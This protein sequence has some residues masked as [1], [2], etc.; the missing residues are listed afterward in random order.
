MSKHGIVSVLGCLL[1][2]GLGTEADTRAFADIKHDALVTTL[3]NYLNA[4]RHYLGFC[5]IEVGQALNDKGVDVILS[6]EGCRVGFQVKSHFDVTEDDFAAK[7]KRQF[8]EALSYK[9]DHYYILICSAMMKKGRQDYKQRVAHLLNEIRLFQ[10]VN[11]DAFG[12]L[13]TIKYFRAP[14]TVTRDELLTRKA[15]ADDCLYDF[16]KGYEHLPEVDSGEIRAAHKRLAEEYGDDWWDDKNGEAA[17]HE[18]Q[19]L[20]RDAEAKQFTTKFLPSLPPEV[21]QKRADLIASIQTLL[22]ECRKCKSWQDRSEYKLPLWL[23]H[24]EES[25]IPYTSLSNLLKIKDS[26]EQYLEV[27][28]EADERRVRTVKN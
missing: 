25:M 10:G 3:V 14:A 19:R 13:T 18:L 9:L 20:I 24:V 16:E 17:W 2:R 1:N 11:F 12:P 6:A 28:R 8:A 4:H 5:H 22:Q 21:Q 27:H 7:V 15:I 23:D 26:V